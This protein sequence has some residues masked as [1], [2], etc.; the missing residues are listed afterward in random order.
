MGSDLSMLK[1]WPHLINVIIAFVFKQGNFGQVV[2][3]LLLDLSANHKAGLWAVGW[4]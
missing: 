4:I 2:T 3:L 1:F